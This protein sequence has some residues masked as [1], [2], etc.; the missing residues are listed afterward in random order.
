[1]ADGKCTITIDGSYSGEWVIPC[2]SVQYV[3]ENTLINYS[4][5][6]INLYKS[7]GNNYPYIRLNFNSKPIYYA[8]NTSSYVIINDITSTKFNLQSQIYRLNSVSDLFIMSILLF[9]ALAIVI[10]GKL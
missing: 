8:N 1:M 4:N 3:E 10:R 5:S 9:C 2:N 6:S 7:V